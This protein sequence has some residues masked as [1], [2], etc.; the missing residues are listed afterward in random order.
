MEN[1][2]H[3]GESLSLQDTEIKHELI[4]PQENFTNLVPK[5]LY[6]KI[7]GLM[8]TFFSA[9]SVNKFQKVVLI[10]NLLIIT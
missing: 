7:L 2:D 8:Y 3:Y 5:N 9:I 10:G 6:A 1:I 4:E